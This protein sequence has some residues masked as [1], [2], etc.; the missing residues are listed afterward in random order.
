MVTETGE[1]D[2]FRVI[3]AMADLAEVLHERGD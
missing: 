2:F 3:S 1:P